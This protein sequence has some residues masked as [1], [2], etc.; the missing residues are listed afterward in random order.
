MEGH[1]LH[2]PWL[3]VRANT[4]YLDV[5]LKGDLYPL[6][7]SGKIPRLVKSVSPRKAGAGVGPRRL[8]WSS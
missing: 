7:E 5:F 4:T 6:R 3:K 1:T 8:C 2:F